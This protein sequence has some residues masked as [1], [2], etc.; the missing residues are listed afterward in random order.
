[1]AFPFGDVFSHVDQIMNQ[2]MMSPF[3]APAFRI[4]SI[5]P[6]GLD[7]NQSSLMPHTMHTS[8]SLQ[9]SPF[10]SMG[11]S[12]F[13]TSVFSM[14]TDEHGRPQVYQ[15]T[16]SQRCG[17][18]GVRE[19]KAT[20]RDS[21]TGRQE[22]SVGHHIRE[23]AHVVKRSRN[24]YNGCEEQ[25]EDFINVAEEEC[26]TFERE[27]RQKVGRGHHLSVR[28][29]DSRSSRLALPAPETSN[30][31]TVEVVE[32]DGDE[33]SETV[34]P[35][36]II[37]PNDSSDDDEPSVVQTHSRPSSCTA[38]SSSGHESRRSRKTQRS[39]KRIPIKERRNK[40]HKKRE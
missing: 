22:M 11:L 17:P 8:Q 6:F 18:D 28:G 27:Y 23:R 29:A 12:S 33:P 40:S 26:E 1:M 24:A 2:F 19:T 30:E 20:I 15:E 36:E 35:H 39:D 21:R 25:E 34:E 5:Q 38:G 4:P 10:S 9:M 37:E 13:S 32:V 7:A 16:R 31:S 14:T 3:S